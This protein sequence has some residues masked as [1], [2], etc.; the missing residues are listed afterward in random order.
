MY[1]YFRDRQ[2]TD[3]NM[4]HAHCMLD[5]L[6]DKHTQPVCVI[7]IAF[8][9]QQWLHE[10]TSLLRY[11]HIVSRVVLYKRGDLHPNNIQRFY[12]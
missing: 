4:A 2:A 11:T 5:K 3:D 7:F 9:L 1:K 8:P 6:C 12:C 10:R